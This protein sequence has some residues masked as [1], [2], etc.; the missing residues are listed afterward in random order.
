MRF[1]GNYKKK[2][3]PFA[4]TRHEL[5]R[6]G[7]SLNGQSRAWSVPPSMQTRRPVVVPPPVE[8]IVMVAG[9]LPPAGRIIT[10]MIGPEDSERTYTSGLALKIISA[11]NN[12]QTGVIFRSTHKDYNV[13]DQIPANTQVTVVENGDQRTLIMVIAEII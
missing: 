5:N 10:F 7:A 8:P 13:G 4:N 9:E 1:T 3:D 6:L 12:A 2:M 11:Q